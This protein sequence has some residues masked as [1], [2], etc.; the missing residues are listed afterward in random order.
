M[1]YSFEVRS[2]RAHKYTEKGQIALSQV[3]SYLKV[4]G[5]KTA[6]LIDFNEKTLNSGIKRISM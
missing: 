3:L 5:L 1:Y 4:T 2:H 6:S